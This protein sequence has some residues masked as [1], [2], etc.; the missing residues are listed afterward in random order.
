MLKF[1]QRAAGNERLMRALSPAMGP[2]NPFLPEHR[3][4]PYATWSRLR[5]NSPVF[6]SRLFGAHFVT[7]YEDCLAVLA[8]PQ[9]SSDRRDAAIMKVVLWFNRNQP[10]FRS[11]LGRSLLSLEG[12][13]HRRLRGLVSR[14][15]TPRRVA[16][17]R[18]RLE[19]MADDLL[20][21]AA[22]SGEMELVHDFAYPFPVTAIAELLGVPVEDRAQFHH[23]TSQ[24]VQILDPLQG[25]D[26]AESMRRAT[27][28]LYAYFRPILVERRAEPRDDLISAMI[29]AEEE[30]CRLDEEDLLALCVLIL[31]AGHETTA[32]LIGNAVVTLLRHPDQRERLQ[33]DPSLMPTAVNE[34]LRF[35]SPIQLTDRAVVEDFEL[36]GQVFQ[37]GQIIGVLLAG[38]NRDPRHFNDPDRLDLG[39][40]PNA[41]LALGHGAHFCLGAQLAKLETEIAL[42]ALLRRF[43]KFSGPTDPPAW[44]RSMLL[45]GPVSLPLQL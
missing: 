34:F 45:R 24:L 6:Y 9:T 13:D 27:R 36:G 19:A 40:D 18:P 7:R 21:A 37:K 12:A 4:D 32:N 15:F 29:Q 41:H 2:L 26:G 3:D 31:A 1:M 16:A 33:E 39:R 17:L 5:E 30:G 44:R 11:F 38:G 43:P 22:S 28:E 10:E 42:G 23:W 35:E 25:R 14:A 20:D 8:G